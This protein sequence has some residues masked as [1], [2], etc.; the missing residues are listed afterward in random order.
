MSNLQ[1]LFALAARLLLAAIFVFDGWQAI[2][3][4]SGTAG[5]ME[6]Y[7]VPGML[8][9]LVIATE[10]GG[11]LLVALG[12]FARYAAFALSGFCLLT[13]L[14]FHWNFG[15]PGQVIHFMKDL[16]IA[17]GFQLLTAFGAGVWSLDAWRKRRGSLP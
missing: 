9:P 3:N 10:L 7:G 6:S 4:Y 16:A 15:D 12:L 2:A 1:N 13:A 11:G 5:Y 17:G 14:F 8:L